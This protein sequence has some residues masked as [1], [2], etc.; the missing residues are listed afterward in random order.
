ML[1]PCLVPSHVA[2]SSGAN[3][4][5][6]RP[7]VWLVLQR[8]RSSLLRLRSCRDAQRG[9][10]SA[11]RASGRADPGYEAVEAARIR[12]L[13][14]IHHGEICR[15]GGSLDVGVAARSE[16]DPAGLIKTA[17]TEIGR[18]DQGIAGSIERSEKDILVT[19][20]S[21]LEVRGGKGSRG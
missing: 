6:K 2:L 19:G 11:R 15:G 3:T 21:S 7:R 20:I 1:P 4:P 17:S 10:T 8:C 16:G 13:Q 9:E 18:K 5:G 12:G 14:G